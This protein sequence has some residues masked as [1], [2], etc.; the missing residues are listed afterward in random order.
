[1]RKNKS[2][3]LTAP[4]NTAAFTLTTKPTVADFAADFDGNGQC[5][6]LSLMRQIKQLCQNNAEVS[7]EYG[8]SI[9]RLADKA[10]RIIEAHARM[11]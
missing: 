2:A 10:G 9:W 3:K 5:E 4:K 6:V 7:E 8:D 11:V 1:M